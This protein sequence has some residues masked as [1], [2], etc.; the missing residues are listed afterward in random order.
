MNVTYENNNKAIRPTNL[1]YEKLKTGELF[2]DLPNQLGYIF[3]DNNKNVYDTIRKNIDFSNGEK[4]CG[5]G[6]KEAFSLFNNF[7]EMEAKLENAIHELQNIDEKNVIERQKIENKY[8]E[9]LKEELNKF[10]FNNIILKKGK[11]IYSELY[12]KCI[13]DDKIEEFENNKKTVEGKFI[14][15]I[16][17]GIIKLIF[18]EKYKNIVDN[19]EGEIFYD[20]GIV[21][22]EITGDKNKKFYFFRCSFSDWLEKVDENKYNIIYKVW[23]ERIT[24]FSLRTQLPKY[25]LF[26]ISRSKRIGSLKS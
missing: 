11:Y 8:I 26:S 23:D 10:D 18:H 24:Y 21:R 2:Y 14:Q 9:E 6:N 15:E 12:Y 13:H 20:C 25:T 22:G 16:K 7:N 4:F 1:E 5:N 17:N 3:I 19:Y